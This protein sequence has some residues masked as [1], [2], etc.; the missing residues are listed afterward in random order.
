MTAA[1]ILRKMW[2]PKSV[3]HHKCVAYTALRV[4]CM[5]QLK[6][7]TL[8]IPDSNVVNDETKVL[9]DASNELCLVRNVVVAEIG[10]VPD[11]VGDTP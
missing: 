6:F 1:G 8:T 4:Y 10:S 2:I 3:L 7:A 9:L 11:P 5:L